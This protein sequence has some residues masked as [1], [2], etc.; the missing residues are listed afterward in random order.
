MKNIPN[1][2]ANTVKIFLQRK[3]FDIH[4]N[5]H[6]ARLGSFSRGVTNILKCEYQVLIACCSEDGT[7]WT[8][9]FTEKIP[10]NTC[11]ILECLPRENV[12]NL[13]SA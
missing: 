11:Y 3:G 4:M 7:M 1:I 13:M 10:D 8:S 6:D 5:F 12:V 2:S 9:I